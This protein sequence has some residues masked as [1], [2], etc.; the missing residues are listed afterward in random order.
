[1]ISNPKVTVL[2]TVYN[3]APYLSQAVESI[4][5]Q[6]FLDWE[7]IAV[8]N[9]STDESLSILKGYQDDSRI[10]VV[11]FSKNMGRVNALKHAFSL[12][13]G[14]FLAILDADDIARK[15][16]LNTQVNFLNKNHNISLV[17]SWSRLINSAGEVIGELR[18]PTQPSLIYKTLGW[19]NVITHSS[20]MYK[21]T[22]ALKFGGYSEHFIW[23]HDF[24][25]ILSMAQI[26]N[27]AMIGDFLCDLRVIKSSM[28]RSPEFRMIVA[29]ENLELFKKASASLNLDEDGINRNRIAI[30][31]AEVKYGIALMQSNSIF[32]GLGMILSRILLNP[33]I[34]WKNGQV[35]RLFGANF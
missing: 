25:F 32:K 28:T 14:E 19:A 13:S 3:G 29:S 27:I 2:M 7:L 22:A 33:S 23:G 10:K 8:D 20:V 1:M 21:K 15:D 34:L 31:I 24:S 26:S 6:T 18:P 11:S 9:C 5:N 30:S 16:R 17:A 4:I 35:R 12:S